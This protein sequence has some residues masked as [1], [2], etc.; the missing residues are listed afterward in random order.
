MSGKRVND[1]GYRLC[2][3]GVIKNGREFQPQTLP[4]VTFLEV[5]DKVEPIVGRLD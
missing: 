3:D 5:S 2:G 1:V 4:S